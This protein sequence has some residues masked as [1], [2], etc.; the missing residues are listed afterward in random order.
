MLLNIEK[1]L[2]VEAKIF[3]LVWLV[4]KQHGKKKTVGEPNS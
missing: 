1:G 2:I 3:I 4:V